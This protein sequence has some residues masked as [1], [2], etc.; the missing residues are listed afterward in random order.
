M[1]D[2]LVNSDEEDMMSDLGSPTSSVRTHSFLNSLED[3]HRKYLVSLVVLNYNLIDSHGS[4][5]VVSRT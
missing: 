4:R 2:T 1:L 3:E 5:L